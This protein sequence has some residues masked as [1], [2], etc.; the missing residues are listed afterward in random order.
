[1]ILDTLANSTDYERLH[2]VFAQAFAFLRTLGARTLPAG[3]HAIEGDRLYAMVIRG[4]G[5]GRAAAR[6]ETHRRYI[7]IQFTVAGQDL[8][9]WAPLDARLR[10]QGFDTA[11]DVEMQDGPSLAWV[12]VPPDTFAIFYPHDAHAPMAA[13]GPLHKIVVK[14][15]V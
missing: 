11:K 3:R 10:G 15:A 5:K 13:T 8:I 1:M 14:V 4:E 12:D 7:D 6:L 9:G 2:P